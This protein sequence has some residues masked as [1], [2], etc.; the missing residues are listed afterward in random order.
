[1]ENYNYLVKAKKPDEVASAWILTSSG[2]KSRNESPKEYFVPLDLTTLVVF[3][4]CTV[5]SYELD[6]IKIKS[7]KNFKSF[8]TFY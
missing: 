2:R 1:M 7:A 6:I 8:L 4:K 5:R 3:C